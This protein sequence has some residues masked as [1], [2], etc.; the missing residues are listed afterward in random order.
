MLKIR[1]TDIHRMDDLVDVIMPTLGNLGNTM[2]DV[3]AATDAVGGKWGR[4][5]PL[6]GDFWLIRTHLSFR[7]RWNA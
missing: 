4:V 7:S 6:K 5:A 3:P 2:S 1:S